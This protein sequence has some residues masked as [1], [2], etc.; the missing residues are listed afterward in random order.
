MSKVHEIE[1]QLNDTR[2]AVTRLEQAVAGRPDSPSL[3]LNLQ[4]LLK[5]QRDLEQ[6]L[7]KHQEAALSETASLE[8]PP[9]TDK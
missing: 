8:T 9:R 5:R 4:A 6:Q 7:R 1:Q 3:R 2:A